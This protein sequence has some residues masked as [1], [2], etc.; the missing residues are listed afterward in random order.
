MDDLET[1]FACEDLFRDATREKHGESFVDKHLR[2]ADQAQAQAQA[3][4]EGEEA[5][6]K[7]RLRAQLRSLLKQRRLAEKQNRGADVARLQ[8][9][10]QETKLK[11]F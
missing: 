10:I 9:R 11:L 1:L 4:P 2:K 7:A 5:Q 6:E 3:Q 8:V